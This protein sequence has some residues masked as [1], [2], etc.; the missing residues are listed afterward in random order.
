MQMYADHV[1][2]RYSTNEL[3]MNLIAK[4]QNT[5]GD[6]LQNPANWRSP[7]KSEFASDLKT[8]A[9]I[10]AQRD[11]IQDLIKT[12]NS[13]Q[14]AWSNTMRGIA[15]AMSPVKGLKTPSKWVMRVGTKDPVSALRSL[16]FHQYLG[17][18][19]PSQV[20]VQ[21]FGAATAMAAYPLKATKLLPK[22]LALRA[23]WWDR[24]NPGVITR[25]ADAAGMKSAELTDIVKE[26][27]RVGLF[28]SLKTTADYSAAA[29]GVS[30]TSTAM[31]SLANASLIFFREGE[32]VSR[33][34]GYLLSRDLF[35]SKKPKGYKL[36]NVDIDAVARDANRFTLNL[37]RANAAWWQ[38]G[39]LSIPTQFWQVSAKFLENMVGGAF[40]LGVRKWSSA[41]KAK[42]L[43]GYLA[44]FGAGGVPF[45]E[46]MVSE[47]LNARKQSTDDPRA[48][49]NDRINPFNNLPPELRAMDDP[50]FARFIKGGL[51]QVMANWLTGGDPNLTSRVSIP[52]GVVESIEMYGKADNP[53]LKMI[54]GAALP[55]LMRF[56]DAAVGLVQIW[57]PGQDLKLTTEEYRQAVGEVA[58]IMSSTRN[59]E[60]A[61]WWDRVGYVSDSTGKRLFPDM[62]NDEFNSLSVWQALGFSPAKVGWSYDLEASNKYFEGK[63]K[64]RV[65]AAYKMTLRYAPTASFIDTEARRHAI[66]LRTQ[67]LIADLT[68]TEKE[69]FFKGLMEKTLNDKNRIAETVLK[70]MQLEAQA[71]GEVTPGMVGN[72]LL[73]E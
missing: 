38:K 63:V 45:G 55:G 10:D 53:T 35:L 32:M 34:Y 50:T 47:A 57:A 44:M 16:T 21:G 1:A 69:K 11:F 20:L 36:T 58:K 15:D 8:V 48:M 39:L 25:I 67:L 49:G 30:M 68:D 31:K 13:F 28:D 33:G 40:G 26:I 7:V 56:T 29:N 23:V 66:N 71:D 37:T 65:D 9:A 5:F 17:F 59:A 2:N 24:A 61:L 27:E 43:M 46:A 3:K 42:I 54:G 72:P 60:K 52:A 73:S 19:N 22:N 70:A 51:V 41:E 12:P 14:Q 6:Y 64:E 4:F 18:F 62:E